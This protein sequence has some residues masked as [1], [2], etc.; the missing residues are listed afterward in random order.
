MA[1]AICA[2]LPPVES[3]DAADPID[4]LLWISGGE[5]LRLPS[6][7][8]RG[9]E[10][11]ALPLLS[12]HVR[13]Q[14]AGARLVG[15]SHG[16]APDQLGAVCGTRLPMVAD[17]NGDEVVSWWVAECVAGLAWRAER[18]NGV[19]WEDQPRPDD[20]YPADELVE[21]LEALVAEC[22]AVPASMVDTVPDYGAGVLVAEPAVCVPGAPGWF[23]AWCVRLVHPPKLALLVDLGL[24]RWAGGPRPIVPA[25][26][27]AADVVSKFERREGVRL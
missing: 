19:R 2:A 16:L 26:A 23:V 15:L 17:L 13:R 22:D 14:L 8:E 9:G 7:D 21:A 18:R 27:W 24:W 6:G 4:R 20:T 11:D 5:V 3:G 25:T 1:H 10:Y 12:R